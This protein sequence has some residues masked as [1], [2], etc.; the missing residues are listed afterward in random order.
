VSQNYVKRYVNILLILLDAKWFTIA[1]A[2][3]LF[4]RGVKERKQ[5]SNMRGQ[6]K[7]REILDEA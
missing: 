2:V 3:V 4:G 6:R 1:D 5:W 7:R